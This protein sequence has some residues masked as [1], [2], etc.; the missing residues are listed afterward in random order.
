MLKCRVLQIL[1][2]CIVIFHFDFLILNNQWLFRQN[3]VGFFDQ[4]FD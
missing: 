4:F 1:R 2:F 3:R